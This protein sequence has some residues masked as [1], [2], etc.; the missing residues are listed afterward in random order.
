M[1]I[2]KK[3]L[4]AALGLILIIWEILEFIALP[5]VLVVIGMICEMPPAFYRIIILGYLAIFAAL[6]LLLWVLEKTLGK[7]IDA[8]VIHKLEKWLKKN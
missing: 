2:L 1:N 3:L 7:R 8:L 6:Q 4:G 5:A